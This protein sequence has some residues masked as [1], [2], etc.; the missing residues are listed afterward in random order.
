MTKCHM[1]IISH[2]KMTHGQNVTWRNAEIED[3]MSMWQEKSLSKFPWFGDS[4][5]YLTG[6]IQG[7]VG[8]NVTW[9]NV[10]WQNV[11]GQNVT[12]TKCHRKKCHRKNATRTK[13]LESRKIFRTETLDLCKNIVSFPVSCRSDSQTFRHN[14]LVTWTFRH[15][16]I[17]SHGQLVTQTF[18]HTDIPSP[19]ISSQDISSHRHF[20]T[21]IYRHRTFRH[22]TFRHT[23]ISSQDISSHGH[24]VTGHFVTT[25]WSHGKLVT[26]T[27]GNRTMK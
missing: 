8:Q 7:V 25:I 19:D 14:H 17:W 4:S 10:T 18:R 20:V 27:F 26:R 2:D 13:C 5:F 6:L 9:Q 1:D 21:R 11:T 22:R 24:F 15:T 16:D 12:R 3:R 23:D